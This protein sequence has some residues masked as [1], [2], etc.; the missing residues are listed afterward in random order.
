[1]KKNVVRGR[2]AIEGFK[3]QFNHPLIGTQRQFKT[4]VSKPLKSHT[5]WRAALGLMCLLVS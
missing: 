2:C 3:M 5:P 4:L 1:M